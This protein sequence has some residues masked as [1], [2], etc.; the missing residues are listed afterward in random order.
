MLKV[1]HK[2][3]ARVGKITEHRVGAARMSHGSAERLLRD[4]RA[5]AA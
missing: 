1:K 5:P 2:G 4:H 3:W